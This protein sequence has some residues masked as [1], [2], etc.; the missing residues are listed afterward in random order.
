MKRLR[1]SPNPENVPYSHLRDFILES[2]KRTFRR[3]FLTFLSILLVFAIFFFAGLKISSR[4]LL[5]KTVR[6]AEESLQ[7]G[8]TKLEEQLSIYSQ[9]GLNLYLSSQIHAISVNEDRLDYYDVYTARVFFRNSVHILENQPFCGYYLKNDT[10]L[11]SAG[12]FPTTERGLSKLFYCEEYPDLHDWFRCI[13][14][15]ESEKLLPAMTYRFENGTKKE[16]LTYTVRFAS[17]SDTPGELFFVILPVADAEMILLPASQTIDGNLTVSV[18]SGGEPKTLW[19]SGTY[20]ESRCRYTVSASGKSGITASL[21]ISDSV[22]ASEMG[23]A[24]RTFTVLGL[25]FF[26]AGLLCTIILTLRSTYQLMTLLSAA[27]QL[28]ATG[29]VDIQSVK[30][31][32][33]HQYC[34]SILSNSGTALK[35][36]EEELENQAAGKLYWA[37]VSLLSG[38]DVRFPLDIRKAPYALLLLRLPAAESDDDLRA[39][40][41]LRKIVSTRQ[42]EAPGI[43]CA[44]LCRTAVLLMPEERLEQEKRK[45]TAELKLSDSPDFQMVTAGSLHTPEDIRKAYEEAQHF[46]RLCSL[47]HSG[48]HDVDLMSA[49]RGYGEESDLL[50]K[51]SFEAVFQL[52]IGGQTAVLADMLDES[53][54]WFRERGYVSEYAVRYIYDSCAACLHTIAV[55]FPAASPE[56]G[57]PEYTSRSGVAELFSSLRAA[58][59]S[60]DERLREIYEAEKLTRAREIVAFINDNLGNPDLYTKFVTEH[61]GITEKELQTCVQHVTGTSFFNYVETMRMTEA[62][63]LL[64]GTTLEISR[65]GTMCGY[66]SGVSF[67]RAFNRYFDMPP[68]KMRERARS[69]S[70]SGS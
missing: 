57:I 23:E 10:F 19:Q 48:G 25:V 17:I 18:S 2:R 66:R 59:I 8:V 9:V 44:A 11:L 45:L 42:P 26:A 40:S 69:E 12:F 29:S 13:S 7:N 27:A 1:R 30:L 56:N 34:L 54:A 15:A 67:A 61:F 51:F 38:E 58:L 35:A 39:Q 50:A 33:E 64:L 62:Q 20:E 68:S 43:L 65:I 14:S 3:Y 47:N 31:S 46:L 6:I 70:S 53:V 37:F 4:L 60:S 41:M 32:R 5:K 63:K 49:P 55:R 21:A 36:Y 24:T 52:I 22:I 28:D 16:A